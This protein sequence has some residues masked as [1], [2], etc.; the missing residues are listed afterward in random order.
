MAYTLIF[1][2]GTS[3]FRAEVEPGLTVFSFL[4]ISG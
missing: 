3:H 2:I 1:F 4:T